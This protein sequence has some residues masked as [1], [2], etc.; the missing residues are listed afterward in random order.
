MRMA[1]RLAGLSLIALLTAL[2][3][4]ATLVTSL[5]DG[6]PVPMPML[7]GPAAFGP[8][9]HLFGPD[10]A[11]SWLSTA[12]SS[13]FGYTGGYGFGANGLWNG[14]LAP[15]AGLNAGTGSMTFAFETPVAGVAGFLNY[16]PGGADPS[17]IAIYDGS[18]TLLESFDLTFETP[19]MS[20]N[21]GEFLGFLRDSSEIKYFTLTDNFVGITSLTVQE[22]PSA[23]VPEPG[24][25]LL[26]GAGAAGLL[27]RR[28][29]A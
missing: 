16:S 18:M 25:L 8:G 27:A 13:V 5:P 12:D 11:I 29:L 4:H 7:A 23:A 3:A 17:A 24:T 2:P 19:S 26:V 6:T 1:A 28:R 20:T 21:S 14:A 9:P 15:M 10:D 22:S